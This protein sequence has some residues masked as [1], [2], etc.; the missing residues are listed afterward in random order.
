[1]EPV[2]KICSRADGLLRYA[3]QAPRDKAGIP[4]NPGV[5]LPPNDEDFVL[6]SCGTKA[7][8]EFI[9]V[10]P[11]PPSIHSPVQEESCHAADCTIMRLPARTRI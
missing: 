6:T 4:P 5:T 2:K 7:I 9:S 3:A 1:M 11:D 10:A 8:H